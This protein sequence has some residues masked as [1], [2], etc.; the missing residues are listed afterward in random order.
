MAKQ[1]KA[2]K[3]VLTWMGQTFKWDRLLLLIQ[4]LDLKAEFSILDTREL[5]TKMEAE[6]RLKELLREEEL[7]WALRAK[8]RK[9]VQGDDNTQF[10]HMIA[11]G[12][13]CKKNDKH[14]RHKMASVKKIIDGTVSFSFVTFGV[15]GL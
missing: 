9:I 10:F 3:E 15:P 7:K 11:N 12:K 6:M 2:P 13:N 4:S 14:D 5:E 1:D 8:V